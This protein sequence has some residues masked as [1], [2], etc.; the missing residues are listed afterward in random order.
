MVLNKLSVINDL[1]DKRGDNYSHRPVL[2]VLGGLMGL[3]QV[4][5]IWN[6]LNEWFIESL[7]RA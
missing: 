3:D 1:F 6:F 4:R 7:S 2:A 5:R